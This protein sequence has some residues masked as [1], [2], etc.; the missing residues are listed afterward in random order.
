[1]HSNSMQL[2]GDALDRWLAG[3]EHPLQV[4]DVGSYDVNGTYKPLFDGDDYTGCDIVGGPNVDIF[5][6]EPYVLPFE[7]D[8]FDV[9]ICGQTLEHVKQPWRL[10]AEMARVLVPG[11][12]MVLIAPG[13]GP[14]HMDV[15]AWRFKSDGMYGLAEWAGL[16]MLECGASDTAPW[17]DVWAV[18]QK[19]AA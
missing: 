6:R 1:M 9:V 7:D 2:M 18:M 4:L 11:G 15:D 5:M 12:V 16:T 14:A 17:K 13:E 19:G 8:L 3:R 10:V